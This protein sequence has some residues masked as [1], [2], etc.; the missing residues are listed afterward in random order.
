M[1]WGNNVSLRCLF[2]S[3]I[4]S[5]LLENAFKG[6]FA[7]SR[8][9]SRTRREWPGL[10]FWDWDPCMFFFLPVLTSGHFSLVFTLSHFVVKDQSLTSWEDRSVKNGVYSETGMG[11]AVE[12][13]KEVEADRKSLSF[14]T[15]F[16]GHER[17]FT[18]LSLIMITRFFSF[19]L[20]IWTSVRNIWAI[21]EYQS[22]TAYSL[23]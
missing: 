10:S 6:R 8:K 14:W 3:R 11:A 19:L 21:E 2:V 23:S 18:C 22:L 7:D 9:S 17:L 12:Q 13:L 1:S 15:S 5:V 16:F 20:K 4:L